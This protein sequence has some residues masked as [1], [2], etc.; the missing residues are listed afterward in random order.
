MPKPTERTV[1]LAA[2]SRR[3]QVTLL[4]TFL[5]TFCVTFLATTITE[6]HPAL[7]TEFVRLPAGLSNAALSVCI[8]RE[9]RMR[10]MQIGRM[11]ILRFHR[12][13]SVSVDFHLEKFYESDDKATCDAD[14]CRS[15]QTTASDVRLGTVS[16]SRDDAGSRRGN[17][18]GVASINTPAIAIAMRGLVTPASRPH[19]AVSAAMLALLVIDHADSVRATRSV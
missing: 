17:S 5:V 10:Q 7:R 6:K 15:D 14:V 19:S 1:Q 2:P 18:S 3:A 16:R 12:G 13:I 4:A 8:E 9:I 11:A